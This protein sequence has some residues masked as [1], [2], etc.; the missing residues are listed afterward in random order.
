[1]LEF[2]RKPKTRQI[3][4]RLTEDEYDQ[5]ARLAKENKVYI[6]E[7]INVLIRFALK[8]IKK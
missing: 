3:G 2:N 1:M 8:E 7:A 5:I 4:I 6:T